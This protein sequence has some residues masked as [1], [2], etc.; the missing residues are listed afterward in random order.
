M[1]I[2]F[3]MKNIIKKHYQLVLLFYIFSLT[4]IYSQDNIDI[5]FSLSPGFYEAAITISLSTPNTTADIRLT[6]DGSE[7]VAASFK[8]IAPF[9]ISKTTVIRARLFNGSV[10]VS[11][12]F[13]GTYLISE[14]ITLPVFSISTNPGNFFDPDTGIY[15]KGPNAETAYPYFNANFW[16]DWERPVHIE[17]FE[18]DGKQVVDMDAGIKIFGAWSRAMAQ[19]SLALFARQEYGYGKIKYKFFEDR[20]QNEFESVVLRNAGNDGEYTMIRDAVMQSLVSGVDLETQAYR[21][22]ILFINGKYWGI[23]DLREKINEHFIAARHNVNPDSLDILEANNVVVAGTNTHYKSLMNFISTSDL[24]KPLNYGY[25]KLRMDVENFINYE[26]AQIYFDNGDWPGNNIKYWRPQRN[27]GKWRWIL[28]DTDFGFGL[29]NDHAYSNNTLNFATAS[30]GPNWP[31]PPWSTLL[32]RKLL[33]NEEFKNSFISRFSEFSNTIFKSDVVVS[34][35]RKYQAVIDPEIKRH[36]E[37]WGNFTY[38]EWI[39]NVSKLETFAQNRIQSMR[40]HFSTRFSLNTSLL[41]SLNVANSQYGIIN[42]NAVNITSFPWSGSFYKGIPLTITAAPSP[43]YKFKE[44]IGISGVQENSFTFSFPVHL[45][46]SAVFVPDTSAKPDIVINEINYNSDAEFDCEDWVE[47]YNNTDSTVDLSG[48][49]F[50]DENDD[51]SFII[52]EGTELLHNAYIV[53]CSDTAKFSQFFPAVK[54][55]IG[56]LG[57]SISNGGELIRLLDRESRYIDSVR[58]RDTIPWPLEPDGSG[59]TLSLRNPSFDN[60]LAENWSSSGL[61]GTPGTKNDVFTSVS[62][63]KSTGWEEFSLGQNY[64]NPFNY[65]TSLHYAFTGSDYIKFRVFDVLG[66]QVYFEDQGFRTPGFYKVTF[67]P[68]QLSSGIYYYQI[69]NSTTTLT[70]LMIYL[71]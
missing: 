9:R 46:V 53:L 42:L 47:L 65:S 50:K 26:I 27:D 3:L 29:Y 66:K 59:S 52:P 21:P 16:Q 34:K 67:T 8:Y 43:G 69:S 6:S 30:N 17:Y 61:L 14:K 58:F 70:K 71:K 32:L 5:K 64:P 45:T 60:S 36:L 4:D 55:K 31:N 23:H 57:F 22:V 48:W 49:I 13:T 33:V 38:D 39:K 10:P 37:R 40:N 7:P 11:K 20:I 18:K 1:L 41:L 35:I 54:N 15:E 24:T 12:T 2:C 25:V 19:K 44:W 28:Y 51:N 63:E 62:G 56:D 68:D